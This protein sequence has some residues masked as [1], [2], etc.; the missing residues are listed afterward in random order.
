MLQHKK[1]IGNGRGN[2][3]YPYGAKHVFLF[4]NA[5]HS[6]QVYKPSQAKTNVHI[7]KCITG[8]YGSNQN[9]ASNVWSPAQLERIEFYKRNGLNLYILESNGNL[10]LKNYQWK[11]ALAILKVIYIDLMNIG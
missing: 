4:E 8:T 2:H 11:E 10:H 5:T 1:F 3:Q 6:I 9:P 7:A